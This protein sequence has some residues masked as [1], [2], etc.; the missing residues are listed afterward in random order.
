MDNDRQHPLPMSRSAQ[1]DGR[2]PDV[3]T[4]KK[5]PIDTIAARDEGQQQ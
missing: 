2:L 3:G 4:N 1:V 5:R